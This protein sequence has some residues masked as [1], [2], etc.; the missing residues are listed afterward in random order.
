[1]S[2][3]L[4][5]RLQALVQQ[6]QG[7]L[8]Q[9]QAGAAL[10]VYDQA[11]A[12][13]PAQADL[14]NRRG[15]V[16]QALGRQGEAQAAYENAFTLN[17][18]HAGAFNNLGTLL[19]LQG[20][21]ADAAQRFEQ[22]VALRADH[23]LAW[24]NLGYVQRELKALD[25]SVRSLE[26]ALAVAPDKP[27]LRGDLL[28]GRM[29][30]CDWAQ[31]DADLAAVQAGL[32]RG[33]PLSGPFPLLP[34]LDDPQLHRAAAERMASLMYP[35]QPALGPIAP[36]ADGGRLRIGYFSGD[37]RE[38]PVASLTAHLFECH[39]RDRFELFAFSWSPETADPLQ[40][41]LRTAFE[42][43]IDVR[44]LSDA[45]VAR[46]ARALGIDIAVDLAGYTSGCRPNVF[47]LRAAPVQVGYVGYLGTM[48]APYADHLLADHHVVPAAQ[49]AAY[50]ESIAWLPCYQVNDPTR[51]DQRSG[52]HPRRAGPA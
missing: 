16:L 14:H 50:G 13:D 17:P 52:L 3:G 27:F 1:M 40:Q 43:W 45:D 38:H 35:P 36:R 15:L 31:V 4:L 47:A 46:Q 34:A 42:H 23:A 7:L 41:R 39:D 33:L 24:H 10:A 49:R 2:A 30:L 18:G 5:A 48:G 28:H 25:A 6:A 20:R 8:Q 11:L 29:R 21:W 22:A 37:F 12:L 51:S 9:G 44:T 26:R 19:T 32:A